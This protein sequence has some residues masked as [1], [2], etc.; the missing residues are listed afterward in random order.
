M[1]FLTI[2]GYELGNFGSCSGDSGGPIVRL[3][4]SPP[5]IRYIQVGIVQGGVG[6]CGDSQYPGIYIRLDDPDI[7]AFIQSVVDQ[8]STFS[9]IQASRPSISISAR[10][11][12]STSEIPIQG[13]GDLGTVGD[14]GFGNFSP[15]QDFGPPNSGSVGGPRFANSGSSGSQ[16]FGFLGR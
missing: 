2:L 1:I 3:L 5:N 15:S 4:T 14:S 12:A 13:N 10:P 6:D 11:I 8:G 9:S 16:S 7:L